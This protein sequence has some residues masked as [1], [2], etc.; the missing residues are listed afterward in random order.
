MAVN[1]HDARTVLVKKALEQVRARLEPPQAS[2]VEEFV[3]QFYSEA[4]AD[5][6]EGLDLYGAA[7]AHWKL[8]Q[9]RRPGE[10][11]VKVYDPQIDEHAWRSTH[12]VVEIV[13][14]DM[15]FLVDSVAMAITRHGSAIHLFIHPVLRVRRDADGRLEELLPDDA[16]D[17]DAVSESL[18]HVEI[19]RDRRPCGARGRVASCPCRRAGR[20]RRLAAR[21][22]SG[23]GRRSPSSTR[24]RRRSTRR[25]SPRS[26]RCWSGSTTT[27]SR[28]S[29]TASTSSGS[30]TARTC[31]RRVPGSGLGILRER[32]P[33]RIS[34]S[35]S[36]LPPEVRRLARAPNL[37]NLTKANSRATVHR[38]SY[39]DYVGVKRFARGRRGLVGA[40]LPRPLHVDRLQREPVADPG[41]A[42]AGAADPR[43]QRLRA[44]QPRLQGARRDPR[45]LPARRAVPDRRGRALRDG[46][47]DPP[48]RR[49]AAGARLRPPGHV[50]P[51][52]LRP[53]L[54]AARALQRPRPARRSRRSCSA[55]SAAGASTGAPGSRSR[56]SP[57]C[58]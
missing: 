25:T 2:E 43:P 34:R 26:R 18:I 54:P 12:T 16:P 57:G 17:G 19:D 6:L 49:A 4:A 27:T 1:T 58:T 40:A 37:L 22:G 24:I 32:E 14:D 8:V 28:S 20:S 42:Q 48:P 5:D 47:G 45:D 55:P 56:C 7:L 29:A 51:L 41:A 50:R 3:R 11:K 30:R 23:C 38:P 35:F 36:D 15:P 53:R 9:R 44:R 39:L 46:D 10:A 31:S 33:K 52:R 13:T 21:C